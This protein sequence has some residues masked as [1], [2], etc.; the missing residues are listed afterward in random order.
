MA[1][2]KATKKICKRSPKKRP[3][4]KPAPTT[5]EKEWLVEYARHTPADIAKENREHDAAIA[6][7]VHQF[8]AACNA[9]LQTDDKT[10]EGYRLKKQIASVLGAVLLD[11][12]AK[13]S[14]RKP[15][16]VVTCSS[17]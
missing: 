11:A 4:L 2:K 10:Q 1:K 3:V 16:V 17:N 12:A 15:N 14:F 5:S 6:H 13:L 8:S 9:L 7:S